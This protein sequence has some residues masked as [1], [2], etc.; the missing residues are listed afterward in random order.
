MAISKGRETYS[1]F[2]FINDYF[3]SDSLNGKAFDYVSMQALF[4]QLPN[5]KEIMYNL[6]E[7]SKRYIN[8][9]MTVKLSGA[10]V[11]DKDLSYFYYLDSGERVFQVIHNLYH[12]IN[13]LCT[14]ELKLKKIM[15]F[16]YHTSDSGD[17]FR[18]VP[19]SEQIK[20]NFLLEK[21]ADQEKYPA[22][23][24]GASQ[25]HNDPDYKPFRPE[26]DLIIDNKPFHI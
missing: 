8:I 6:S 2:E 12:F 26:I 20:G 9:S 1:E 4:P 15:F 25:V 18:D 3:P 7:V 13:F 19:N 24:G 17:N 16:G 22:R 23:M 21:F 11:I 10:A 5:Y 14:H